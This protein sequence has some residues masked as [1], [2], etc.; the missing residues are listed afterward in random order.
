MEKIVQPSGADGGRR[1]SDRLGGFEQ[2]LQQSAPGTADALSASQAQV[3]AAIVESSDDAIVSK[4]LNGIVATWNRGAEKLFGYQAHEVVGN[5]ITMLFPA[6]LQ[7]EEVRILARIKRGERIEHFETVRQRKDGSRIQVSLTVSP[8]RDAGGRIVGASKIARD[9]TSR[10]RVEDAQAAVFEFTD[11]LFRAGSA[12]DV[13][14]AALDAMIRALG[15]NRAS[16]LLFDEGGIMRFAA[17]RGLSEAYR[18][19]VEGHSPWTRQSKDPSPIIVS[20]I[21]AAELDAALK[22]TIRAEGIAA[23]AFMPLIAHGELVG[24]FMTYYLTPHKFTEADM[25]IAVTIARQLGFSVERMRAEKERIT[26]ERAKELLLNESTH[27]IKNTL[28]TIQAMA[29]QTLRGANPDELQSFLARLRALG[30]AHELLAS[31]NWHR[32]SLLDVVGRAV[33]PFAAKQ[34]ERFVVNGSTV[35]V[36][37]STS[38]NLTLCLHELATNAIKYGALSNGTGQVRV[39]WEVMDELDLWKLQLTWKET[40]GPPVSAPKRHGFG[41]LLITSTGE[42]KTRIDYQPDGVRCFLELSL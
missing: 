2:R 12:H 42:E 32:A 16:I 31:E 37:A 9:I 20:D 1:A 38:L 6:E 26:A 36:S 14:E 29:G 4:D 23:L 33:K 24:K 8:I 30:E 27:R 21:E 34:E 35:W 25:N 22:D 41:S 7:D 28:G 3:L 13:Y 5:P 15:C 18:Q 11:K 10:K 39:S 19:A 40:G 17:W